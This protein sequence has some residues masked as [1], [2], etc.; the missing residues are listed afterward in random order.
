V[1]IF[2]N[3]GAPTKKLQ[4]V[5]FLVFIVCSIILIG[6]S[7][8]TTGTLQAEYAQQDYVPHELLVKFKEGS[9]GDLTQNK[10]QVQNVLNQV[11]GK[12]KTYLNE[13]IDTFDWDPSD[14]RSRSFHT[15][16]YLFHIRIPSGIDLEYAIACLKLFP[17]VEYVEKNGLH[18]ALTD[19]PL[20]NQ[21]WALYN[22]SNRCDIHVQEAWNISTGNSDIVVAVLDSGIIRNHED[23]QSHIWTNPNETSDGQDNDQNGFVDDLYGWDFVWNDADNTDD[24]DPKYHGTHIAGIIGAEANND[25]GIS[26][27]CW[28]VKLMAVKILNADGY[29]TDANIINA[30]DYATNNGAYLT[31]NSYGGHPYSTSVKAAITRAQSR[32]RLFVAAAGNNPNGAGTNNDTSPIY[33]ASYDNANIISVLATTDEDDKDYYSMYGQNSVDLGAPGV[34]IKSTKLDGYHSLSGTS[35]AAPHVAGAAALA[36]GVCPGLTYDRPKGLIIDGADDVPDLIIKCVS[37]GRLNVYNV[38]NNIT[39]STSPSAPSNL[40]AYAKAWDLIELRWNDNSNDEAGFEIQRKDQH[41]TAYLHWNCKD[42]N[43][44]V[45]AYIEDPI[46]TAQQ[47]T[48]TYRVRA[49]NKAGISSFSNSYSA[50]VLYTVPDAPTNLSGQSPVLEQNVNISWSNQAENAQYVYIE[51]TIYGDDNWQVMA[52]LS[53]NADAYSDNSAQAGCTY[54]YRVR[55]GNPV[56][57]SSYSNTISIEVIEW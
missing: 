3:K 10:W 47:R 5:S 44:T 12:I 31:N 7:S 41:K 54:Q 53:F 27:V 37:K 51:R 34:N 50:S 17:S 25:K 35:M 49:A 26:G 28:D 14:F 16:P 39:G 8:R 4:L 21:Q 45:Y 24:Y 2:T 29:G 15:D 32:N 48:Y 6:S 57:Y 43:S 33:P 18:H 42:I 19:D 9:V 46:S 22:S 13:E 38:L 11:Q 36:L 40:V 52:T 1:S 23:L 30:I 20:F 55:A 56:G